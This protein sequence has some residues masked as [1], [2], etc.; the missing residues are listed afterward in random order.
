VSAVPPPNTVQPH[1][2]FI[3]CIASK[4]GS[5]PLAVK[6]QGRALVLFRDAAQF[7]RATH[8]PRL[9]PA[10]DARARRK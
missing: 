5:R 9:E 10:H 7:S 8:G 6:V 1:A 3:A 4:L 2:W